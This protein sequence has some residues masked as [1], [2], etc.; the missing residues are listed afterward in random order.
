M[1][2]KYEGGYCAW[3]PWTRESRD[4][5]FYEG[6]PP[7]LPDEGSIV[8]SGQLVQVVNDHDHDFGHSKTPKTLSNIG[9]LHH[10]TNAFRRCHSFT[11]IGQ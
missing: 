6:T 9:T 7:M 10:V 3:T 8:H 5:T 11:S 1:Q 2:Y 4:I